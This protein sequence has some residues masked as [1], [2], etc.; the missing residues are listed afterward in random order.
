MQLTCVVENCAARGSA[1]WAEHGLSYWLTSQGRHVLLDTG[2]SGQVL[3]HNLVALG[4]W[5]ADL[6]GLAL[7]HAHADHTGG[8]AVVQSHWP[9]A[10]VHAHVAISAPRYSGADGARQIGLPPDVA[11]RAAAG[12]WHL[13]AEPVELAP[14][15]WTTG[16]IA[17]RPHPMGRSPQ[18]RVGRGGRLAVDDYADDLSLVLHVKG[19]VALLCGCCHAGLRNTLL[20]LREMTSAPLRAVIGGAH[21]EYAD[22]T[23]LEAVTR[24]LEREGAP[25]LYLCHCTGERALYA[26]HEAFGERVHPC[27]AGTVIE[28]PDAELTA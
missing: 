16:A 7:S 19:G 26:L 6:D 20:R 13:S 28:L 18:H 14:N 4:L 2:Q 22:A 17:S 5:D 1:L 3:Q 8:L 15:I 24:C 12:A 21:L 23:E 9:Q 27:P 25:E 11:A 10:P